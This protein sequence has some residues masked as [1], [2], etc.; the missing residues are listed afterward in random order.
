[1]QRI[2]QGQVYF[3]S[4]DPTVGYEI[5]KTRPVVVVSINDLNDRAGVL[6]VVPGTS[7]PRTYPNVVCILSSQENGLSNTTYFQCHQLR[8]ISPDRIDGDAIGHLTH[9]DFRVLLTGINF[10]LTGDRHSILP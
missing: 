10:C 1:M 8:A 9:S 3:A 5:K 2:V 4:L 7:T 6:L